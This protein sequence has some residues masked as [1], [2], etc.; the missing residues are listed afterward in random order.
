[1]TLMPKSLFGRLAALAALATIAALAFAALAIGTVL[2]RFV[3]QGLDQ[4]LDAQIALLAT[5][6]APDGKV[7]RSHIVSPAPF[8]RAGSGWGWRIDAPAGTIASADLPQIDQPPPPDTHGDRRRHDEREPRPLD[9]RDAK[10]DARHARSTTVQTGAGPVRITASAPR[11]IV[12]RPLRAAMAPLLG[13]LALLGIALAASTLIQLRLGLRPLGALRE[14]LA[15]VR[16]GRAEA[17]PAEQPAELRPLAEELN[18]LLSENT[19]ALANARSHVANLAHG[20]KTPLAA[21]ALRLDERGSDPD[22]TMAAEVSRMD[23]SIRHHLGRARAD[24]SG[25]ATRRRTPLEP[26][27]DGVAEALARIHADRAIAFSRSMPAGLALAIDPQDLDELLGNL[28]DN[29]WRWA[30]SRITL[31]AEPGPAGKA[32]ITIEDDG[33]GIAA[34]D[35]AEALRPGRRLD[36]SGDGHGFGLSIVRELTELHGGTLALEAAPGGGLC[37]IVTL[38]MAAPRPDM[39]I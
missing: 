12:E 27:V 26:A 7:D 32:R 24:A 23:R 6:I 20:L 15:S 16:A 36:E 21:L 10:G 5:A 38:P 25:G 29:G 31:S 17:V 22:G 19:A 39:K 35:R 34:G 8:D 9:W 4:R 14:S 1:M 2:E 33:P 3:M 13:S 30:A 37:A 11:E 28:L 18:A